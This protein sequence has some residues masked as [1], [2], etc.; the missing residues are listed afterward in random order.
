M[1]QQVNN[2][3]DYKRKQV[4]IRKSVY[5]KEIASLLQIHYKYLHSRLVKF[6]DD[7]DTFNATYLKLTYNYNPDKDFIDQFIYYFNLLKGAYYRD[8]KVRTYQVTYIEDNYDEVSEIIDEDEPTTLISEDNF[9][10]DLINDMDAL[11][12]EIN[13]TKN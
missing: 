13:Q 8:S 9:L 7:E 6:R 1:Q 4:N 3:D 12:K 5:N 2:W 10:N 11:S